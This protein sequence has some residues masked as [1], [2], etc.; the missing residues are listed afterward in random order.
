MSV[1]DLPWRSKIVHTEYS[2]IRTDIDVW[3]V[4]WWNLCCGASPVTCGGQTSRGS[5]SKLELKER[6]SFSIIGADTNISEKHN[7]HRVAPQQASRH[8]RRFFV[9]AIKAEIAYEK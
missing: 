2:A 1:E 8:A 4:S 5:T 9:Q 7:I 3:K 6:S